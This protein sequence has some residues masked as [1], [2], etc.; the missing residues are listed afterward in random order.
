MQ[1]RRRVWY[2]PGD[3][4]QSHE[5]KGKET[6]SEYRRDTEKKLKEKQGELTNIEGL[7]LLESIADSEY[8]NRLTVGEY[9]FGGCL[10][11]EY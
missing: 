4:D 2:N 6:K 11:N 9:I 10:N 1:F 8:P 7:V 5:E 3:E